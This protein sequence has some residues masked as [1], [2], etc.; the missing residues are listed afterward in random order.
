M[1]GQIRPCA[2]SLLLALLRQGF[3]RSPIISQS[4]YP[5]RLDIKVLKKAVGEYER[6]ARAQVNFDKSVGLTDPSG[7][8]GCDSG[9]PPTRAKLV[10]STS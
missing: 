1:R 10:G 8:S 3:P 5:H 9:R 4:L 6:I 2:V 7:F